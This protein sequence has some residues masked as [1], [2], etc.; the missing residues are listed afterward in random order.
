MV[1]LQYFLLTKNTGLINCKQSGLTQNVSI[2][3]VACYTCIK[4]IFLSQNE[5]FAEWAGFFCSLRTNAIPLQ[6]VELNFRLIKK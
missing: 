3:K 6:L 5:L 1:Q 4:D 2:F